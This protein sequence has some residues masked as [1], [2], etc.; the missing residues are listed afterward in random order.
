[1]AEYVFTFNVI[2]SDREGYY[3]DDWSRAAQFE[4]IG[5][6]KGDALEALWPILGGAPSGRFWKARQVG[7]AK[8]V[9]LVNTSDM[10]GST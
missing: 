3:Y 9:R 10:P 7:S 1:M 2:A 5:A 6:T 8:D 4:V